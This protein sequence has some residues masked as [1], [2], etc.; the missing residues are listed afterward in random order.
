[1]HEVLGIA[2]GSATVRG[3]RNKGRT[4]KVKAG[5]A[6]VIPA[7]TGHQCLTASQTFM[8]VGAYPPMGTYGEC[9]PTIK[10]YGRGRK[11]VS[12]VGLPRT[13]PVFGRTG[14]LLKICKASR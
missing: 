10:E 6:L 1:M 14:P 9:K 4:L 7:G 13:D 11:S 8:A 2:R 3:G 12:K 5:D